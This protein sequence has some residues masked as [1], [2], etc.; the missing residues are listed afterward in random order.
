ME[1]REPGWLV[2]VESIEE[3]EYMK[4]LALEDTIGLYEVEIND[5]IEIISYRR[6]ALRK[7]SE[8]YQNWWQHDPNLSSQAQILPTLDGTEEHKIFADSSQQQAINITDDP[9]PKEDSELKTEA[10]KFEKQVRASYERKNPESVVIDAVPVTG[11]PQSGSKVNLNRSSWDYWAAE[12]SGS[13]LSD[14]KTSSLG[15]P[16]VGKSIEK[17]PKK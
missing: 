14:G 13:D 10:T 8:I 2:L 7:R 16:S 9:N 4:R 17:L 11:S 5:D 6:T 3:S 12:K 15:K 1:K